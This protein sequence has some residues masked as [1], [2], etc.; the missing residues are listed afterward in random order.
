[1]K[2]I[3]SL[4]RSLKL[5]QRFSLV[6]FGFTLVPIVLLAWVLFVNMQDM[7]IKDKTSEIAKNLVLIE[8]NMEKTA[9]LCNMTRQVFLNDAKLRA[10]LT[11]AKKRQPLSP[12]DLIAFRND[13]IGS[14]EKI[15][16]ANPYLYQ[17]RIYHDN[18]SIPEIMPILYHTSRMERLSWA[19]ENWESGQWQLGYVDRI[20]TEEVMRP[21]SNIM[22]LV[23]EIK[24]YEYGVLGVLEVAVKMDDILPGLNECYGDER[25]AFIQKSGEAWFCKNDPERFWNQNAGNILPLLSSTANTA[26]YTDAS[27]EAVILSFAYLEPLDGWY[28]VA[29]FPKAITAQLS[30]RGTFFFIVTVL[31]LLLLAVV[32]NI[33]TK[34]MLARF[35]KIVHTVA[36]VQEGALDVRVPDVGSDEVGALGKQINNMLDRIIV[37]MEENVKRQL[38]AKN[39]EI[40]ALH[41][42]IN[43]HFIYNVLESIKMMAEVDHKY[44]IADSITSLGKLLRY[45]MQWT[46]ENVTIAEEIENVRDYLSLINIR[47]DYHIGLRADLPPYIQ[48]QKIPKLSLQP[49]VENA[50]M[51]GLAEQDENTTIEITVSKTGDRLLLTVT[52]HGKGMSAEL[53]ANLNLSMAQPAGKGGYPGKSIGLKNVND[54]LI[55]AFGEGY[56]LSLFSLQGQYT[57]VNMSIPYTE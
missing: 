30:G 39:S 9:E 56:G 51:H 54:R 55:M 31:V 34:T 6:V 10:F 2:P 17:V 7:L 14:L 16:N 38:L 42:Q 23:T 57:S 44:E 28:V 35:Y 19:Q 32:I 15:I 3:K 5:N 33:I 24:G 52:D 25:A 13:C 21:R 26:M 29:T 53:M 11:N 47:F 41:S 27:G 20:F 46:S 4:L 43:A 1:M 8:T 18:E 50:V 12:E 37:L 40:R 48:K 36:K 22:S 45:S 49:I